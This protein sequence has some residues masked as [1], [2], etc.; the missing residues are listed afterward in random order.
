MKFLESLFKLNLIF[1]VKREPNHENKVEVVVKSYF[2]NSEWIWRKWNGHW[3]GSIGSR[4]R[5]TLHVAILL[6]CIKIKTYYTFR[7]NSRYHQFEFGLWCS[8]LAGGQFGVIR[9]PFWGNGSAATLR[10]TKLTPSLR[11]PLH[12]RKDFVV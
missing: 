5:R 1:N 12:T 8:S 11:L 2:R 4:L 7:I 10:Q 6:I 3:K 9:L